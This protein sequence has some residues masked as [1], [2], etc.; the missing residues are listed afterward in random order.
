MKRSRCLSP[1]GETAQHDD[2][3]RVSRVPLSIGNDVAVGRRGEENCELLGVREP[4][5]GV[6]DRHLGTTDSLMV[7]SGRRGRGKWL[8]PRYGIDLTSG[9]RIV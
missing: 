4:T 2:A 6:D 1:A 7:I 8:A 5:V 3:L 9:C